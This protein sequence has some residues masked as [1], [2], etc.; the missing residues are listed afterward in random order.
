MGAGGSANVDDM[1]I[2]IGDQIGDIFAEIGRDESIVDA[3][4]GEDR[5]QRG[6]RIRCHFLERQDMDMIV[7]ERRE[8]GLELHG[9]VAD[10]HIV[11]IGLERLDQRAVLGF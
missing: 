9:V 7:P 8:V 5:R 4:P 3:E 10:L 1:D 6:G 2:G 11:G